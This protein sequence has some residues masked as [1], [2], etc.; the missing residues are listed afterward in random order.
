MMVIM[1]CQKARNLLRQA[2]ADHGYP[3]DWRCLLLRGG[4]LERL[5][6][7]LAR[8]AALSPVEQHAAAVGPGGRGGWLLGVRLRARLRQLCRVVGLVVL[9]ITLVVQKI[10]GA[11]ALGFEQ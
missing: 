4:A 9:L 8:A 2:A 10:F 3:V 11:L 6:G 5:L 7:D 1:L